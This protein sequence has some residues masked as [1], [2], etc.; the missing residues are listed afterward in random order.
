MFG[1]YFLEKPFTEGTSSLTGGV[2]GSSNEIVLKV[3]QRVR[4]SDCKVRTRPGS[5][6]SVAHSIE[7]LK[8]KLRFIVVLLL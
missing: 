4:V 3:Y 7:L 5:V 8:Q 2:S 1:K 6:F